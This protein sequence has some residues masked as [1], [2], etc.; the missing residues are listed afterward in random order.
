MPG[1]YA[2]YLIGEG[3]PSAQLEATGS[4]RR[5]PYRTPWLSP[6]HRENYLRI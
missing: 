3:L 2:E 5:S 4:K 6:E 1:A